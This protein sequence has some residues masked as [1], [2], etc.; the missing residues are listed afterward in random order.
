MKVLVLTISDRASQGVYEDQS[1]PA[2][3]EILRAAFPDICMDTRIVADVA[4]EIVQAFEQ[5]ADRDCILT[6]GGTGLSDRDVTPQATEEYCD[7]LVPGVAEYLRQ[8][9]ML[10]TPH[11]MLSRGVC[12]VKGRTLI[13]NFPGSIRGAR[14]CAEQ[15]CPILPHAV[16]MMAGK[17]H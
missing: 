13:I 16:D 12:G 2:I 5:H 9:S 14:F 3:V 17:W 7:F 10:Q 6:T 8:Q 15:I 4:S 11:A 1:G